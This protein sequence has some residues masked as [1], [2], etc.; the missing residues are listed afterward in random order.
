MIVVIVPRGRLEEL[1][2]LIED[3][4]ADIDYW[5]HSKN[6]D[7]LI[8][9]FNKSGIVR[10]EGRLGSVGEDGRRLLMGRDINCYGIFDKVA[11]HIASMTQESWDEGAG[12]P[13]PSPAQ[14]EFKASG[15]QLVCVVP[16]GRFKEVRSFLPYET[17][18]SIDRLAA[19]TGVDRLVLRV[20]RGHIRVEGRIGGQG[21]GGRQFKMGKVVIA[22]SDFENLVNHAMPIGVGRYPIDL[23]RVEGSTV[24][25][26]GV[27]TDPALT[28]RAGE[29]EGPWEVFAERLVVPELRRSYGTGGVISGRIFHFREKGTDVSLI[30]AVGEGG[31]AL[32]RF[33]GG[34]GGPVKF[35]SRWQ[36]AANPPGWESV[37]PGVSLEKME[38][39]LD[40]NLLDWTSL[41]APWRR[42]PEW[43]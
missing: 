5:A 22:G 35:V 21:E 13:A 1:T 34:R 16:R 27:S 6:V 2:W 20:A 30:A 37:F 42:D 26:S 3:L 18:G 25:L 17:A 33:S 38:A 4:D 24:W 36:G 31:F 8:L 39:G 28:L 32:R 19:T 29:G 10:V 43:P 40:S 12:Q 7:R 9:K 14:V 15:R 41:R 11:A 23:Q